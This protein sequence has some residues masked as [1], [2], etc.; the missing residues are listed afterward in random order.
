MINT[1]KEIEIISRIH[2]K[3]QIPYFPKIVGST[4]PTVFF[5]D[6]DDTI[7]NPYDIAVRH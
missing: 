5:F 1:L 7:A 2:G 3:N 4:V 6:N